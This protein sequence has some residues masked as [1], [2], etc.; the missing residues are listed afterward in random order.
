[1]K[2]DGCDIVTSRNYELFRVL[3]LRTPVKR[4]EYSGLCLADATSGL[5]VMSRVDESEVLKSEKE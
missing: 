2:V 5:Y 1:M 4:C 3:V